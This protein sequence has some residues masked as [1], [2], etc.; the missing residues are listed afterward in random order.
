MTA[1]AP[2]RSPPNIGQALQE[3]VT[4]QRQG[5][6]REAEKI[7]ARVLKAVP[8]QFDA[9]NL[10]GT[11]KAQ[12]GQAGE[13]YRL[14]T[15]ALKINPRAADAWVNLGFVLH[16]LKRDQE[17]LESFDKALAL[18]P[19]D[20]EAMHQRGHALLSLGRPQEALAAFERVLAL[21]PHHPD[22]RLN[23]AIALAALARHQEAL[24]DFDAA[25]AVS[26]ANPMAH[27]NRGIA[28]SDLQRPEEAVVAY[29][30][31]L[32][33]AP[34]HVKAWNNRGL[35]LAALNRHR[36][37]LV[38]YRKAVEIRDDYADAHFH[39]SLTL[40]TVGDFRRGFEEYEW[41]WRR[42]GM[43]PRG[44]GRPLWLGDYPLQ[45]KTIL[46]HAEQ[47]L[48]DTIQFA[49][50]IPSL[51]RMGAKVILEVQP[52]LEALLAAVEGVARIVA[53]GDEL[54]AFD[55]HCPL[56]SLPLAF[57]TEPATIPAEIPYLQADAARIAKWRARLEALDRPR[58]AIAW[59]GNPGHRNDRNRS[60]ALS[61]LAALW[62]TGCA[63]F[64]SIQ[65]EL[66][67][68][69]AERLAREPGIAHIGAE[70]EDFA[71]TAAVVAL[72]DLVVT[73]DTSVAHLAGAMGRPVF[74]LLPFAPDWRWL[75]AGETSRWYPS[76]RLFRQP[77]IGDWDSVIERLRGELDRVAAD[78]AGAGH[79]DEPRSVG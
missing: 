31:A 26:P 28:L 73:V 50:Y 10:L 60:I 41:R 22:A 14:I 62:P 67:D 3:A 52:Q 49:R 66:R 51:A 55:V 46:L 20:A 24:V 53:R 11:V 21:V 2:R 63:R 6:L 37:A 23:R 36:E 76:A 35:A 27:Y 69:D 33:I 38:S 17:A 16:T 68:E 72:V 4:L 19:G 42:A 54:P 13:A 30:R 47:G 61:R 64:V 15:A 70:L 44:L 48:G 1:S 71:D 65:R 56:G 8:D 12:R 43:R 34:D 78:R 29:D 9:L 32:S 7:Y 5:R 40:L 79:R 58:I 25:V 39:Q 57:K 75:V 77:S 59:S 18:Q 45:R 74:I